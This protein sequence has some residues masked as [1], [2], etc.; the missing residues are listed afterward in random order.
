[1]KINTII[2]VYTKVIS[3]RP[4]LG[5]VIEVLPDDEFIIHWFVRQ[6]KRKQFKALMNP[7]GSPS[8]DILSMETIMFSNMSEQRTDRSFV[9]SNYWLEII[10]AEYLELDRRDRL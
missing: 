6:T 5:R 4:W 8:T 3:K 2:A 9:L 10:S 1:M 7:D